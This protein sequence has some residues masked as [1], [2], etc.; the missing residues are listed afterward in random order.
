[1]D[2]PHLQVSEL[3]QSR[4]MLLYKLGKDLE[5]IVKR[6]TERPINCLQ[7][8]S[9]D[10]LD[11]TTKAMVRKIQALLLASTSSGH[12]ATLSVL[13]YL[14]DREHFEQQIKVI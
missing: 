9:K 7:G 12:D 1:M 5:A 3:P 10:V 14:F 2:L 6:E 11:H 13:H 4:Q 8:Q